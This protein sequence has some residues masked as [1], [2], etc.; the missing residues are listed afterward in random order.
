MF[1]LCESAEEQRRIR[2]EIWRAHRYRIIHVDNLN[3]PIFDQV[4]SLADKGRGPL[5]ILGLENFTALGPDQVA[6]IQNLNITRPLWPQRFKRTVVFWVDRATE[7]M[8]AQYA[9]DFYRFRSGTVEFPVADIS[10]SQ[11]KG[12][13]R[14]RLARVIAP[15]SA[16]LRWYLELWSLSQDREDLS[17][18]VSIALRFDLPLPRQEL[19]NARELVFR[20]VRLSP[21][22]LSRLAEL[23]GLRRLSFYE[24]GVGDK[25][26]EAISPLDRLEELVVHGRIITD[27]GV[28]WISQLSNLRRLDL[29][30]SSISDIGVGSLDGLAR[31]SDLCCSETQVSGPGL[32]R[33][34]GLRVLRADDSLLDDAS[35]VHLSELSNLRKL[36]LSRTKL[37]GHTLIQLSGLPALETLWLFQTDLSD[38]TLEGVCRIKGLHRISVADTKVTSKGLLR[39]KVL[40]AMKELIVGIAQLPAGG[41]NQLRREFAGCKVDLYW[42]GNP[43]DGT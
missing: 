3:I 32:R 15:P 28:K 35:M 4:S 19:V 1:V 11:R 37:K 13:L 41:L 30:G 42:R 38:D 18:A 14:G 22:Q 43:W 36:F 6:A 26:I 25:E 40:S 20:R 2:K 16:Q 27:Q 21:Q 10:S 39:L 12:E 34:G 17:A 5:M 33:L 31:L 9:P 23:P 24:C 8:L 7:L 29:T